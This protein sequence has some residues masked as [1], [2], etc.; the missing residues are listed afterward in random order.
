MAVSESVTVEVSLDGTVSKKIIE[1]AETAKVLNQLP[2]KRGWRETSHTLNVSP[3]MIW[4]IDHFDYSTPT[5]PRFCLALKHSP[6][7]VFQDSNGYLGKFRINLDSDAFNKLQLAQYN[8]PVPKAATKQYSFVKKKRPMPSN[9]PLLLGNF[10]KEKTCVVIEYSD[11]NDNS[12]NFEC[13]MAQRWLTLNYWSELRLDFV[14]W[15]PND[16][17]KR[18]PIGLTVN[19]WAKQ[20]RDPSFITTWGEENTKEHWLSAAARATIPDDFELE[21]GHYPFFFVSGHPFQFECLRFWWLE[22]IGFLKKDYRSSSNLST[23]VN[24][25]GV[26]VTT[27]HETDKPDFSFIATNKPMRNVPIATGKYQGGLTFFN[28]SKKIIPNTNP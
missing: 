6:N 28:T 1:A 16:P 20:Y 22:S 23:V 18:Y 3:D 2:G 11:I 17:Q 13:V 4:E 25:L 14:K 10:E 24:A 19:G 27:R 26:S 9:G 5:N 12:L 15:D 21:A 7:K 8:Q